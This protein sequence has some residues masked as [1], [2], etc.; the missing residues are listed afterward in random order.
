MVFGECSPMYNTPLSKPDCMVTLDGAIKQG[1]PSLSLDKDNA[2]VKA[3]CSFIEDI[4]ADGLGLVL[5]DEHTNQLKDTADYNPAMKK[6]FEEN[7]KTKGMNYV[8]PVTVVKS[9]ESYP[10]LY[11][12]WVDFRCE[13]MVNFYRLYRQAYLAGFAKSGGKYTFG[14]TMFIPQILMNN[15]TLESKTNSYWD[16]KA[17]AE[18]SDYISPMIYTY[19]GIEDCARV[20]DTLKMY[21]DYIGRKIM[22]PT[23]LAGHSEFGEINLLQKPMIKY[24]IFESLMHQAKIIMFWV[25]PAPM[26]PLNL[27]YISDAIRQAGPYEDIILNGKQIKLNASPEWVR[28][29]ALQFEKQVLIYVANY[30]ND[31]SLNAKIRLPGHAVKVLDIESG[32]QVTVKNDSF[33]TDFRSSRGKI[34]LATME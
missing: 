27:Q 8:D 20:G 16:Y 6:L 1:Y 19:Q 23:L 15:T 25:A 10:A 2:A 32:N 11:S 13:R 21:N 18:Y 3:A 24:Q 30:R 33:E 5:D 22:A 29:K 31:V 4:A 26:D 28:V 34:F 9:K 12:A 7:L 14:K 17:L